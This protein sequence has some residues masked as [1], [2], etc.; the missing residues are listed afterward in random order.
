MPIWKYRS[1]DEM[2]DPAWRK[3]GDP[4]LY[5]ALAA[6]WDTSRRLRPRQF[7]AGVH[8]HRSMEEMNRQRDDWDREF[9]R[10]LRRHHV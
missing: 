4:E 3:P 9:V 10:S 6:L 7:P 5:R 1:V 2:P 8:R